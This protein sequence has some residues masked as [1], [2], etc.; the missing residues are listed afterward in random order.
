MDV[1]QEHTYRGYLLIYIH[2]FKQRNTHTYKQNRF[3]TL[4]YRLLPVMHNTIHTDWLTNKT[5]FSQNLD[6]TSSYSYCKCHLLFLLNPCLQAPLLVDPSSDFQSFIN[7]HFWANSA[8]F[9]WGR[10]ELLERC[11]VCRYLCTWQHNLADYLNL[12]TK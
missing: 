10:Q 3:C 9:S 6:H 12:L 1:V 5:S 8:V 7:K 4:G 2:C 11:M